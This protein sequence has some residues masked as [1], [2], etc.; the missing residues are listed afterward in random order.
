MT[1]T[2]RKIPSS[3]IEITYIFFVRFK[4]RRQIKCFFWNLFTFRFL[5]IRPRRTILKF[6]LGE[7]TDFYTARYIIPPNLCSLLQ[8]IS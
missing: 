1:E 6:M 4:F 3:I 8:I 7:K 2:I 5:L